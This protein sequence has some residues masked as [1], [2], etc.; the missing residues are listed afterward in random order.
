MDRRL[1]AGLVGRA[2]G[3]TQLFQRIHLRLS[4]RSSEQ[5]LSKEEPRPPRTTE[6]SV[7]RG[8]SPS[9]PAQEK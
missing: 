6:W 9:A 4:H 1:E 3:P 8:T 7:S 5:V 2:N